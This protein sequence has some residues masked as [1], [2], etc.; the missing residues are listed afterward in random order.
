LQGQRAVTLRV[1]ETTVTLSVAPNELESFDSSGDFSLSSVNLLDMTDG[2]LSCIDSA[3][4]AL[5]GTLAPSDV[6]Y[7]ACSLG[8]VSSAPTSAASVDLTGEAVC[9]TAAIGGVELSFDDGATWQQAPASAAGWGSNHE[10][11]SA[12][13]TLSE[14]D[15]GV[16]AR[17]L[18]EKGDPIPGATGQCSFTVDRT[19]PTTTATLDPSGWSQ[20]ATVALATDDG[21]GSGVAQTVY[22]INGGPE[23]VYA[24]PFTVATESAQVS[25]AS[26]DMA[27]NQEPTQTV[28]PKVDTT[29]PT[30]TDDAGSTWHA[31]PWSL[32]LTRLTP[33]AAD[34]S[35]AG[36]TGGSAGTQYSLD[37]GA[38]WQSGTSVAFPRWKRGGGSGTY[39]V[40]YR[41]TDS[42]GNTEQIESTTVRIDNSLPTSDAALTVAAN[43]ATV[44]LTA[45]DPDS[46]VACLWYSLDGGA[47][48][49]AVYPGPA[50]V[51]VT[52]AGLGTHTLC[53]YA[54]DVAGN[55]QAGYGVATVT[56]AAAGP[57]LK[58]AVA[59]HHRVPRIRRAHRVPAVRRK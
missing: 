45:T 13:F 25:F 48:Q 53:Y 47:W 19:A 17:T 7:A 21:T 9:T 1:A 16:T 37:N 24:G 29:A 8:L 43:P 2:T 33:L 36:M 22:S 27:G 34:G 50:G 40:L 28:S 51:P 26:T 5:T 30:T 4:P 39:D 11:W 31:G 52:I 14:G 59:R 10:T 32:A 42:A 46:G 49:Q 56:N 12:A 44:T 38:S 23:Q 6:E 18:D 20:Q 55:P 41:S 35:H 3:S 54:V 58:P 15:F 57:T